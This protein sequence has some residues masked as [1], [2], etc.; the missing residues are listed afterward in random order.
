MDA[1]PEAP[2]DM[3]CVALARTACWGPAH[4]H[5]GGKGRRAWRAGA[6]PGFKCCKT[7]ELRLSFSV[8]LASLRH[9]KTHVS[10]PTTSVGET[11]GR[12][13]GAG[14]AVASPSPLGRITRLTIRA[15]LSP[16]AGRIQLRKLAAALTSSAPFA[17]PSSPQRFLARFAA[18]APTLP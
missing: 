15:S 2:A 7:K 11:L 4:L 5:G 18:S 10:Y 3:A 8:A 1:W 17:G 9:R 14:G 6:E 12:P 13:S 16:A